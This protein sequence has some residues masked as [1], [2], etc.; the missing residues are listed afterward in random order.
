MTP[1]SVCFCVTEQRCA[2]TAEQ[3][4]VLFGMDTF[5]GPRHIVL[6]EGSNPPTAIKR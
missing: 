5:V 4:E 1:Q 6:D 2:K 3:I